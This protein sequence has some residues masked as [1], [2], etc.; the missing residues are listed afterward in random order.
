M[1]D[2]PWPRNSRFASMRWP[3]RSATVLAIEMPWPSATMVSANANPT[4]SRACAQPMCGS[5]KRGQ[6]VAMYPTVRSA[7]APSEPEKWR[8]SQASRVA[9]ARPMSM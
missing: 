7:V 5:S 4:S 6:G 1:L 3:E 9:T 2:R 8:H